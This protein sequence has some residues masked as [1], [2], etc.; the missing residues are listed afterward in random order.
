[1][2]Q[3]SSMS[4]NNLFLK[5]RIKSSPKINLK[6]YSHDQWVKNP[7]YDFKF[8]FQVSEPEF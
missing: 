1:M 3:S 6:W 4:K 7:G 8:K 2:N 5:N